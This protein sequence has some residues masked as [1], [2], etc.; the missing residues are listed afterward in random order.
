MKI[1]F[2]A[3]AEIGVRETN[4]DRVLIN[5][6]I[7]DM[8]FLEGELTVPTYAVLCDG[9]GGYAGGGIAAETTLEVFRSADIEQLKE[10]NLLAEVLEQCQQAVKNKKNEFPE[11]S[12]MCAT[13][14]GCVFCENSVNIFHAGDSRA[15]RFDGTILAR[16][17]RDHSVV[18]EMI[19]SGQLTEE[20]ARVCPSRNIITRC[21]GIEQYPAEIYVSNVPIDEGEM[22]L[23][24]S[25]GLWEALEDTE[26]KEILSSE[27]S[28][29]EKANQLVEKA[30]AN[31]SDDNTSVCI[32]SRVGGKTQVEKKPFVLD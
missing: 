18:Q 13:V 31:G 3:R 30:L 22:Y 19:D 20:E 7:L 17:T 6:E 21:I 8:S 1:E 11:F 32:C 4:D 14:V 27:L 23:L 25:D 10:P 16:M 15:Y 12:K 28:V 9:C 29:G 26:I 24:C 2:A 5:N